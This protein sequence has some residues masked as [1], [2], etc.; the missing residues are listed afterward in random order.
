MKNEWDDHAGGW[1]DE[2]SVHAFADHVFSSLVDV[3]D[4]KGRRVLDFGCGTGLLSE[5]LSGQVREIVALDAST[6]MIEQ[7]ERKSLP[8]VHPVTGMLTLELIDREDALIR[9]FDV[10]VASSVCAFLPEYD[11]TLSLLRSLLVANGIYVQWDW[12]AK[13]GDDDFGF[14]E[15]RLR[16]ALSNAGF[17]NVTVTQPFSIPGPTGEMPVLM[18]SAEKPGPK[19]SAQS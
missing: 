1:E 12:L 15:V 18:A 11:E 16:H 19:P 4:L 10:V 14:S 6:K 17:A 3:V 9:P 5:R 7:L 2:P 13:D 8:N